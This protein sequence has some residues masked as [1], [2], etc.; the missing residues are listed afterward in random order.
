MRTPKILAIDDEE[1]VRRLITA[2]LEP[3]YEVIAVGDGQEGLNQARWGKPDLILLDLHL[4]GLDGLAVL[5]R[6]KASRETNTI[7]V[8]I[9]SVEG[10]TDALLDCQRAGAL[11][12]IIKP[13]KIEELRRVIQ[14]H[15]AVREDPQAPDAGLG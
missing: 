8:V 10:D 15:L 7:P 2:T 13:F 3:A 5:A 4:P 9:V 11:D 14:R 12:H 6:L 1:G